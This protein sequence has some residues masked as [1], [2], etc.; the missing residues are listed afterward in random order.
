MLGLAFPQ[1]GW[2]FLAYIALVPLFAAI[3]DLKPWRAFR[4]GFVAG[5]FYFIIGV[6]WVIIAMH[7]YGGI[8][9]PLSGF[10][11]VLLV[12]YLS[13]YPAVFAY[14]LR[15][16]VGRL[17]LPMTIHAPVLWVL[18]EWVRGWMIT[19]FPWNSLGYSQYKFRYLIQPADLLGVHGISFLVV[20]VNAGI[21]SLICNKTKG[22]QRYLP[23]MIASILI[24]FCI[25]YSIHRINN[26][27]HEGVAFDCLI[28]QANIPQEQK[29][30]PAYKDEI[31]YKYLALTK[32][33]VEKRY[34]VPALVV[35]PEAATPFRFER[36]FARRQRMIRF[37]ESMNLTLLFG[38]ASIAQNGDH[39]NSSYL[40]DKNGRILYKYHKMHLVPFGEYIP[41]RELLFFIDKLVPGEGDFKPGTEHVIMQAGKARMGNIICYEALF[42][43]ISAACRQKGAN[44]LAN[45]TNEAWFGRSKAAPQ[46]LSQ[47]VFRAIENKVPLI[48]AANTGI[49][50][51]IDPTGRII[52]SIGLF[53]TGSIRQ[54]IILDQYDKTLYS[55]YPAMIFILMG[56]L[57]MIMFIGVIVKRSHTLQMA[58]A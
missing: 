45:L 1:P 57:E 16:G 52:E 43:G 19:G 33:G 13:L 51:F 32:M 21:Y 23:A 40:I 49:S 28:I 39:Q 55:R 10:F 7:Y 9:Y 48:R 18:L 29:W 25:G 12:L 2:G 54:E 30:N 41:L 4:L 26:M 11:M 58:S 50:A 53:E 8:S 35:W 34:A 46:V 6:Y 42:P 15:L 5:F 24:I 36:D 38:S 31:L 14:L 37:V 22:S 44:L 20:L 47:V 3:Q 56:M 17:N 27:E